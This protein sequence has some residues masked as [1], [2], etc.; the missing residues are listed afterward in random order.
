MEKGSQQITFPKH[1]SIEQKTLSQIISNTTNKN[2]LKLLKSQT[3]EYLRKSLQDSTKITKTA[4]KIK[5]LV[6]QDKNRFC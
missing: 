2:K 6:S 1:L 5:S 4:N 3:E